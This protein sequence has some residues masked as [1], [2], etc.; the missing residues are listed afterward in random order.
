MRRLK[1]VSLASWGGLFLTQLYLFRPGLEIELY[2]GLLASAPLLLPLPGLLRDRLYT[3]RWTGFPMLI[4]FCVGI[5]EWVA[6]PALRLY[7]LATALFSISLFL[8][9]IYHARYLG[10]NP[11][12]D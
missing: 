6:N 10:I 5:S 12:R 9:S 3:Y 7:G 2:W 1:A 4:Y 8:A 11:R